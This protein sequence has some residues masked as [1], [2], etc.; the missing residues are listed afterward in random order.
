VDI[1]FITDNFPPEVNAP[2]SRTFEHCREW[3]KA[4]HKVTVITCNPNFPDGKL[5]TGHRN[6]LLPQRETIEGIH[7]IRVWSYIT[8]NEGFLKRVLDYLSFALTSFIAG[9]RV[10]ADVIVATSPQFFT[11]LSGAAL[12]LIK[13]R[14][15]IFELR[16]LWPE[17]IAALGA[18]RNSAALHWLERLE[19]ALYRNATRVVPVTEAFR[20]NLI[21]RGIDPAKIGVVTNGVLLDTFVAGDKDPEL[22]RRFDLEGKTVIAYIGTHG[23]A[24]ALGFMLDCAAELR[25][26]PYHFLFVGSGA[27][28]QALLAKAEAMRLDNVSFVE[29]V[30]KAEV[31]RFIA[32]CDM[33]L[34]PLKKADVF[35]TVIPSKIFEAAAMRR[36][37][38]LGV[39][40]QAREIVEEFGAGRYFEPENKAAFIE[41]LKAAQDPDAVARMKTG[42]DALAQ[43]YDRRRLA[44]AMLDELRLAAKSKV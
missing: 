42:C 17:S 9:L 16:D 33:M 4:G 6:R 26:R 1:L 27:E 19:L 5:F 30:P 3:V 25:G 28:R 41:A 38:L 39:D 35:K 29:P 7:V 20:R 22:V 44:D 13:R 11:T 10:R 18:M 23:A 14:P 12:S 15:W 34:V 31:V 24:H 43:A 21:E 36:P 37:I 32:T 8:A 2:A 40:G